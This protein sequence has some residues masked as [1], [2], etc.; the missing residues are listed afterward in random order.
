ME[1]GQGVVK[2][3]LA[4]VDASEIDQP[5][6]I[7]AQRI[8]CAIICGRDVEVE[9]R[10]TTYARIVGLVHGV[11]A[12]EAMVRAGASWDN[13]QL[14]SDTA[15]PRLE[16]NARRQGRGFGLLPRRSRHWIGG[17]GQRPWAKRS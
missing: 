5:F 3:R 6:G 10:G 13:V 1:T 12:S 11:N 17:T 15:M 7:E 9:E 4:E 8:F 14:D 2:A 16:A